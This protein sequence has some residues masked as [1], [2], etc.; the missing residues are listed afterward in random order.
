MEL[1]IAF[2]KNSKTFFGQCIRWKQYYFDKLPF[3]HAQYSHVEVVFGKEWYSSSEQDGGVRMKHIKDD[4]GHWDYITLQVTDKEYESMLSYCERNIANRY[5]WL[6]IF[7][8]Q[9]L[10]T[11]WFRREGDFF[12]SEFVTKVLQTNKML[13]GVDAVFVSP[14]ML[15]LYLAKSPR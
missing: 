12:C 13:C 1:K 14:A 3:R 4:K 8:A 11:M 7:F 15:H 6:G 5:N 10:G 9:V 2:Y